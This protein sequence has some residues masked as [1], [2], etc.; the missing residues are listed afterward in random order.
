MLLVTAKLNETIQDI[1]VKQCGDFS[2]MFELALLNNISLSEELASG[3]Q[4]SYET[5]VDSD[6]VAEL[7]SRRA[8]TAT[9]LPPGTTDNEGI[10]Y[11]AIEVDFEVS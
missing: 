10:D 11:W 8:R 1:A 4:L 2:A 7:K 5:I 9:A 6:I 3:Q